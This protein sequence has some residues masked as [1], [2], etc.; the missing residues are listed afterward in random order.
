MQNV[1][2]TLNARKPRREKYGSNDNNN[3]YNNEKCVT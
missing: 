3:N 2:N 1:S